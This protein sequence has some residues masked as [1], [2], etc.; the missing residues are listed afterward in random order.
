M[1]E[2]SEKA[3]AEETERAQAKLASE[4][5]RSANEA[6]T[7]IVVSAAGD[8]ASSEVGTKQAGSVAM[9]VT[10]GGGRE[11]EEEAKASFTIAPSMGAVKIVQ[12]SNLR[13]RRPRCREG[14]LSMEERSG[15]DQGFEKGL[16]AKIFEGADDE[17]RAGS[18]GLW[19]AKRS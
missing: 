18:S 16:R 8:S 12:E 14:T 6:S 2:P 19:R 11:L 17:D 10:A 7:S 13:E 15:G 4:A 9:D 5:A 3:E 1:K